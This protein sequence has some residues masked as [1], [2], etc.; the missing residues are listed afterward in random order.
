M[1]GVILFSWTAFVI[2]GGRLPVRNGFGWDGRGFGDWA[3]NFKGTVLNHQL[4]GYFIQRILPSFIVHYGLR[5]IQLFGQ[6]TGTIKIEISD[7]SVFWGFRILD[8]LCT[9]G[10]V[11]FWLLISTHERLSPIKTWIGYFA[12][13]MNFPVL[14]LHVYAPSSMDPLAFF[15]F[16][17]LLYFYLRKESWKVFVLTAL[18]SFQWPTFIYFGLILFLFPKRSAINS[19]N[20]VF[21]TRSTLLAFATASVVLAAMVYLQF[22]MKDPNIW[23]AQPLLTSVVGWSIAFAVFYIFLGT[24][25]LYEKIAFTPGEIIG[26]FSPLKY[27]AAA[28]LFIGTRLIIKIL[29]NGTSGYGMKFTLLH[30]IFQRGIIQPGLFFIAAIIF[31]GP[32]LWLSVFYW[33]RVCKYIWENF[34][35]GM[36]LY[37]ILSLLLSLTSESRQSISFLPVVVLLTLLVIDDSKFKNSHLGLFAALAVLYSKVW[38]P[39]PDQPPMASVT[40][41]PFERMML[42]FGPWINTQMYLVQTLVVLATGAL[43]FY[44]YGFSRQDNT[45]SVIS[46]R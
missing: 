16:S 15:L 10:T 21:K 39:L 4:D 34:G 29:S 30:T 40:E 18:G 23:D 25:S 19:S 33:N 36:T 37:A 22:I 12:L 26:N 1:F 35:F 7:P 44:I 5:I 11:L 28:G 45:S 43:L 13:F 31:F 20:P 24:R 9:L 46:D 14:R 41:F 6:V 27:I 2:W 42:N 38:L 17:V 3:I 32:F 8:L